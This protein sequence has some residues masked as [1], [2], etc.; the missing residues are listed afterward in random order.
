MRIQSQQV[1]LGKS[2]AL[3]YSM[4]G[5]PQTG[6][7]AQDNL[8]ENIEFKTEIR[9][10]FDFNATLSIYFIFLTLYGK[11]KK[12]PTFYQS[13]QNNIHRFYLT[14]YRQ[15]AFITFVYS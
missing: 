12:N 5:E 4:L 7:G 8:T 1:F 10:E 13:I 2:K 14:L 6:G 15:I 9:N 3:P 11:K